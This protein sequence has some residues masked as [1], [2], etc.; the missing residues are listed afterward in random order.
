MIGHR[1]H[2]ADK[3]A[4]KWIKVVYPW[5]EPDDIFLPKLDKTARKTKRVL[6]IEELPYN[7]RKL[8]KV[9]MQEKKAELLFRE[10]ISEWWEE[11]C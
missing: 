4:K 6:H 11:R 5:W 3:I 8:K 9:T 10:G 2:I 7:P 1:L